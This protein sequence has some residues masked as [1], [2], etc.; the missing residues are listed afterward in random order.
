LIVKLNKQRAYGFIIIK[1]IF[2]I[3]MT[4]PVITYGQDTVLL[5]DVE[6]NASKEELSQIGKKREG[7]DSLIKEQF[8]FNTVGDLLSY[9]SPVYIKSYG[10]GAIATTSFRGGS[11]EQTAILWNGFNIQNYML[12][13]A[14]LS[15]L[16]SVLFEDIRVEYG[17]SSSLWGSGAV[18]GSILLDNKLPFGKGASLTAHIGGNNNGLGNVFL[19][20]ANSK[21]RFVSS[22]KI[23]TTLSRR[24]KLI[25]EIKQFG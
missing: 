14:D 3:L 7:I 2:S 20:W 15:L 24:A 12:G 4:V 19:N 1:T 10:P 11:A 5:K 9:N 23:Y 13:Q 8:R 25:R 21:K 18:G 16:P 17:G 6:I 22:S